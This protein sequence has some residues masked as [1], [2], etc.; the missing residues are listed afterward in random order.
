MSE[1]HTGS[2]SQP[3]A[4]IQSQYRVKA[5]LPKTGELSKGILFLRVLPIFAVLFFISGCSVPGSAPSQMPKDLAS[6]FPVANA[7]PGWRISQTVETYDHD[8][9]FNLVD[10]QADSFFA[11]GFEQVAVQRYQDGA[12]I[13]LNVEV[14]QLATPEDAFGL[15]ST[16]RTGTPFTIGNE[17][18]LDPGRRLA[19]WQD[20]YFVSLG[21]LQSVPDSTLQA[22]ARVLMAR[23]PSGGVRPALLDRL[24]G[25]GL[26]EGSSIFFHEEI[27]IQMEV[28][29]GG[30]NILGLSQATNGVLG[31]YQSDA[32]IF[33]LILVEYPTSS[34]SAAGL[35]ALQR[36]NVA[37]LV[38]SD[39]RGNLLGAVIGN[40]S[41]DLASKLL[42]E[43]L[44]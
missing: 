37:D 11:Y 40:V 1:V 30:E 25:F 35:T 3:P 2:W 43:A 6:L 7:V 15:F 18:D 41:P 22:F 8:N 12:G 36:G 17:G 10:G 23:L 14:W 44:K 13:L 4:A 5:K 32:G 31:R 20:R 39:A 42:Q 9:L 33:R 24:P 29:L 34:Q 16:V 38:T 21:A 28:W 19:F 26:V 27:S